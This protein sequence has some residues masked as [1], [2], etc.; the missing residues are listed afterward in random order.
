MYLCNTND[1]TFQRTHHKNTYKVSYLLKTFITLTIY[2]Q[3]CNKLMILKRYST[4]G[5]L[6]LPYHLVFAKTTTDWM[7]LQ[8]GGNAIAHSFRKPKRVL[9]S[10]WNEN[11]AAI[12]TRGLCSHN[13]TPSLVLG[14]KLEALEV[15]TSRGWTAAILFTVGRKEQKLFT[16]L[17]GFSLLRLVFV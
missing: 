12:N 9:G 5:K 10:C 3:R 2:L 15:S 4:L 17:R 1:K 13:P 11:R 16:W 14:N 6:D 7:E 8:T